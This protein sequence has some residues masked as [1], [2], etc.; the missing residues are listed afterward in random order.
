MQEGLS[1]EPK[2]I[3]E[4]LEHKAH[5]ITVYKCGFFVSQ[6]HPLSGASPDG[7]V[8]EYEQLG[9]LEMKYIQQLDSETLNESLLRKRI[10]VVTNAITHLNR[11]HQYFYQLQH[12]MFVTGQKWTDFVV[13]GSQSGPLFIER[14]MFDEDFWKVVLI[15]FQ[16]LHTLRLGMVVQG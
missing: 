10:C 11:N 5:E 4:Y 16:R 3:E 7:I 6:S 1:Q 9:L 15:C 8:T 12:Q 2:I 13:K 14:V